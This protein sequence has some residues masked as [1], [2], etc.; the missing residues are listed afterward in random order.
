MQVYQY[1]PIWV[2]CC[3]V[4]FDF[5]LFS[6]SRGNINLVLFLIYSYKKKVEKKSTGLS[7]KVQRRKTLVEFKGVGVA[8]MFS[9]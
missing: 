5:H 3:A 7:E 1:L 4:D 6:L 8:D 2:Q 9:K